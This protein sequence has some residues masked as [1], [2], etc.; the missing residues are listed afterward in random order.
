MRVQK[1]YFISLLLLS[2]S[3]TGLVNAETLNGK[4]LS[5]KLCSCV[6]AS[7]GDTIAPDTLPEML[8]ADENVVTPITS[9]VPNDSVT[10][11]I[12]K[13][14]QGLMENAIFERTQVGIYIYD[15]TADAPIFAQGE[16]QQ[17]RPASCEKV[18]TAISALKILGTDYHYATTLYADGDVTDSVLHGNLYLRGGFDPL[19]DRSDLRHLVDALHERGIHS[20]EGSVYFDRS[21]KDT[22]TRGWGW[23][24]DDDVT[25]LTPLLYEGK[26]GLEHQ[27]ISALR[28]DSLCMRTD[29][30]YAETPRGVTKIS[31]RTHSIDQILLPMMKKSDNL[32]AESLFYQIA[33][34]SG[35]A[36]ADY[37]RGTR[38]IS[39]F[40]SQA[41]VRNDTYQV[42]DGSGLSLYNYLTPQ[43]LV[44]V[45]RYAYR[46]DNI[47]RHLLPSLPVAGED[48]TLRRRMTSGNAHGNVHAKTGTVEG[49]STLAGYATAP[50]GHLLCFAIMNQGVRHT[51]TGRNFQ[52][53]V[54][55]AL[56]EE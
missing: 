2:L 13:R 10:T 41:G 53:R 51:S 47:Y 9:A 33:A 25:P 5:E 56:T 42:A 19:F 40:L 45:L 11:A 39:Q 49:V 20:V 34:N 54:C 14:L 16:H 55:Q 27:F 48:G 24:W 21:F 30:Q 32:F 44:S 7:A 1:K 36:Y 52:D 31:E 38:S 4:V 29:I 17:L 18:I 8:P 15:L 28:E 50:N 35:H 3:A 12:V 37:K 23:C 22:S 43:L 26:E 6:N 46:H